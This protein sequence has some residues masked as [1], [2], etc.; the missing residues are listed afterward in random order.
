MDW[1]ASQLGLYTHK[2]S[3]RQFAQA[4]DHLLLRPPILSNRDAV[5]KGRPSRECKESDFRNRSLVPFASGALRQ[6]CQQPVKLKQRR[7]LNLSEIGP[8]LR[9]FLL[10]GFEGATALLQERLPFS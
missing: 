8:Q 4:T 5:V 3:H 2:A 9:V 1:Y 10:E 7:P 6:L